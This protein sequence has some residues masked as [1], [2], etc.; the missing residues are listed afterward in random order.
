MDEIKVEPDS[1]DETSA[2]CAFVECQL[3]EQDSDTAALNKINSHCEVSMLHLLQP[4][5]FKIGCSL[6]FGAYFLPSVLSCKDRFD[7]ILTVHRR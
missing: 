7:V 1:G 6:K 3:T 2:A 5:I 4:Y